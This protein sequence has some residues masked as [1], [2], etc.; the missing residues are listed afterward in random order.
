MK[1]TS[2]LRP[3]SINVKR[4]LS[5]K[6]IKKPAVRNININ[7]YK[8][9]SQIIQK[10]ILGALVIFRDELYKNQILKPNKNDPNFISNRIL[11]ILRSSPN[12]PREIQEL[13]ITVFFVSKGGGYQYWGNFKHFLSAS[14][15][16][17]TVFVILTQIL[18]LENVKLFFLNIK[19]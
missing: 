17:D 8:G 9:T 5:V 14:F 2:A 3:P 7:T 15:G 4:P 12:C 19:M 10:Y 18:K 11:E 16:E 1:T 6:T 13:H